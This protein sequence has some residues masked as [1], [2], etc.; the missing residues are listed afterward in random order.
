MWTFTYMKLYHQIYCKRKTTYISGLVNYPTI[1]IKLT[2]QFDT[3]G[4]H[5]YHQL[6]ESSWLKYGQHPTTDIY[7][8]FQE[9]VYY[10]KI[11]TK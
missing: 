9:L 3:A 4:G 11:E 2:F 5:H 10:Q 6:H 8:I 7:I 1:D